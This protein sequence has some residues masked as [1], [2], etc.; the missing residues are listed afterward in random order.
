M[1]EVGRGH[2]V[3]LGGLGRAEGGVMGP[4]A[5]PGAGH[6]GLQPQSRPGFLEFYLDPSQFPL[7]PRPDLSDQ[8]PDPVKIQD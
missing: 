7:L 4:R 3:A 2:A 1:S 5:V 6:D 8:S